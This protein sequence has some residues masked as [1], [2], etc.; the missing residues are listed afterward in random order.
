MSNISCSSP[1]KF[2]AYWRDL[3]KKTHQSCSHPL[4]DP[5]GH[6]LPLGLEIKPIKQVNNIRHLIQD[7]LLATNSLLYIIH[8]RTKHPIRIKINGI[9]MRLHQHD[10]FLKKVHIRHA[11][12]NQMP[13]TSGN[14]K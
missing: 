2:H 1:K 6:Y 12:T 4:G 8:I 13:K 5:I 11:S 9:L 3:T 10:L 7:S 14:N